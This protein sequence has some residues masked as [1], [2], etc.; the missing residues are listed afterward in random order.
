MAC[1]VDEVA[2]DLGCLPNNPIGFVE[3]FYGI[4]LS[5]I[6]MVGMLFLIYGG[7]Q[8]MT[9]GGNPEKLQKGK[10]YI[11]YAIVGLLLAIFGFVFIEFIAGGILRIPGFS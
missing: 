5:L 11:F 9:S 7:Y 4:G 8:V 1:A 10:E 6:G 2:T 3:K